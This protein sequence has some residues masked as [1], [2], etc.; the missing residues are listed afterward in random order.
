MSDFQ[1]IVIGN[2]LIGSATARYLSEL[3]ERVGLIGQ[4]EPKE[5][6]TH[7]V[8]TLYEVY[9]YIRLVYHETLSINKKVV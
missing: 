7:R 9:L 4:A 2:G 5:H 6:Q 3:G 1:S 8:D